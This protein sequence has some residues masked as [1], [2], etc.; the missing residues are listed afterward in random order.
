[1]Q[2]G[3]TLICDEEIYRVTFNCDSIVN[4]NGHNISIYTGSNI[5]FANN[6]YWNINGGTFQ[7]GLTDPVYSSNTDTVYLKNQNNSI[8]RGLQFEDCDYVNITK[9]NFSGTGSTVDTNDVYAVN[10]ANC[11]MITITN[12]LFNCNNSLYCGAVSLSISS[13]EEAEYTYWIIDNNRIY[14]KNA[15][16]SAISANA[17]GSQTIP[18]YVRYN[19][20]ASEENNYNNCAISL[21]GANGAV[22]SHN[23]IND[24]TIGVLLSS[25]TAYLLNNQITSHKSNSYGIN[26]VS[27]SYANL[28][29]NGNYQT[30][31][32]DTIT[33]A[34]SGSNDILANNSFFVIEEGYNLFDA[35][36]GYDHFTG[37]FPGNSGQGVQKASENCYKISGSNGDPFSSVIWSEDEQP[38]QFEYSNLC[39]PNQDFTLAEIINIGS[40]YNDIINR[41]LS[42]GNGGGNKDDIILKE[43]NE[44]T[45][46]LKSL[47]D[48]L[49]INLRRKN[50]DIVISTGKQILTSYPDSVQSMDVISKLYFAAFRTDTNGTVMQDIKSYFELIIQSS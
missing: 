21:S 32:Q 3:G 19:Y 49:N 50:F 33:M 11:P 15:N 31:G 8:W 38:V 41:S 34:G 30:G 47:Y 17:Y 45:L 37:T 48:T 20:F 43:E 16:V 13:N 27:G 26:N 12:N 25:S 39:P 28:I 4:S 29:P 40:F 36:S 23:N 22:I 44:Q 14:L 7:C 5:T 6:A 18:I 9:T 24:Y 46:P 1:M 42:G 35:A 10:I 2:V